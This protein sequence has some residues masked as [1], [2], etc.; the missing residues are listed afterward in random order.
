MR[1]GARRGEG[2]GRGCG[3]VGGGEAGVGGG[4]VA[5]DGVGGGGEDERIVDGR[6]WGERSGDGLSWGVGG[7]EGGA[8]VDDV[9]VGGIGGGFEGVVM[10]GWQR[11]VGWWVC[12][13]VVVAVGV[14]V[15][16]MRRTAVVEVGLEH[17]K[18]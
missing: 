8:V 6:N 15:S 1:G 18:M 13:E 17:E 5:S 12:R 3:F 2:A 4:G 11:E 16:R 10:D 9:V 14:S 7:V